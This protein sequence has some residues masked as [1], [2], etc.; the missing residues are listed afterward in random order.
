M[1]LLSRPYLRTT[2]FKN[3]RFLAWSGMLIY[4]SYLAALLVSFYVFGHHDF[5]AFFQSHYPNTYR[6]DEFGERYFTI[7]HFQFVRQLAPFVGLVIAS[8]IVLMIWKRRSA[9]QWID[10]VLLAILSIK[11]VVIRSFSEISHNNRILVFCCF[12]IIIALK[13]YFFIVLPFYVD[14]VFNFTYFVKEGVFLTSVYANNHVLTNLV[15]S[16]WWKLGMHPEISMRLTSIL[17]SLIFYVVVYS[18]VKHYFNF[19]TAILVLILAGASFWLNVYSVESGAYL[20]MSFWVVLGFI[21][22]CWMYEDSNVVKGQALFIVSC[23]LGFYTSLLFAIPF[24]AL[25][26][27]RS[28]FIRD[29]RNII[30]SVFTVGLFSLLLY[31]PMYLWSGAEAAFHSN[32]E[33][34]DLFFMKPVLF[35]GLSIMTEVNT[36]SSYFLLI[37]VIP[38]ILFFKRMSPGLQCLFVFLLSVLFSILIFSVIV[39]V[40]PPPRALVFSNIIF[41]VTACVAIVSVVNKF[42]ERSFNYAAAFIVVCKVLSTV[43]LFNFGWQHG[44]GSLMDNQF[45]HDLNKLSD[46]LIS[47]KPSLVFSDERD[48]F[49]N[50]Y[51]DY[52]SFVSKRKFEVTYDPALLHEADMIIISDEDKTVESTFEQIYKGEFG[53]ILKKN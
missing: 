51:L 11:D 27:W 49:L 39:G 10:N 25:I 5:V 28:L 8:L 45:Y 31:F 37:L 44:K 29:F 16:I 35:G 41:L 23:V 48:T 50:F 9:W 52:N 17:S 32:V 33:R 1:Q 19:K 4:L 43:Y 12:I 46:S 6:A 24:I 26:F 15:S 42:L 36:K 22:V 3:I 13:V 14:E 53:L 47:H 2:I 7:R 20:L 34:W 40:Y 18:F 21:S 38:C 30:I